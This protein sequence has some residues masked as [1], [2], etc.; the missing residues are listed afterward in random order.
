MKTRAFLIAGFITA[1]GGSGPAPNPVTNEEALSIHCESAHAP[2]A[3]RDAFVC[4]ERR[5]L[6]CTSPDGTRAPQLHVFAPTC[7]AKLELDPIGPYAL[8]EQQLDVLEPGGRQSGEPLCTATIEV[9]DTTPP[10]IIDNLMPLWPASGQMVTVTPESC[11]A[12]GDV[13]DPNVSAYFTWLE[14][15]E[16][17]SGDVDAFD[18]NGV[19][20]RAKRDLDGDGRVYTLGLRAVDASGNATEGTCTVLVSRGGNARNAVRGPSVRRLYPQC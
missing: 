18:C 19:S 6:E 11:A 4:G 8:G 9:V 2:L 7:G 12:V 5:T 1:C 3:P 14:S 20:L 17:M 16:P 13:C 10:K 15:D